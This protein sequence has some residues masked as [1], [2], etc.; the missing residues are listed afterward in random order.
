MAT[1]QSADQLDVVW[2]RRIVDVG[3]IGR[4][5]DMDMTSLHTRNSVINDSHG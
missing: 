4:V 1:V 3:Y 5:I 2:K